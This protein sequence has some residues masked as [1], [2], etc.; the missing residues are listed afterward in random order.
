MKWAF[1]LALYERAKTDDRIHL[2]IG[3]VGAVMFEK[4]RKDFPKQFLNARPGVVMQTLATTNI[5]FIS[6]AP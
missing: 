2:I 1:Q 4:F 5:G 3:D 6:V